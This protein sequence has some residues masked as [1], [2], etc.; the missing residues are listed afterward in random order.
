MATRKITV[1]TSKTPRRGTVPL[2]RIREAVD[3][4]FGVAGSQNAAAKKTKK[5][6]TISGILQAK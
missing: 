5:N 4:V 6:T 3:A 2:S 1:K